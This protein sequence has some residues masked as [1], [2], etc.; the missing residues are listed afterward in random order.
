MTATRYVYAIGRALDPTDLTGLS[1][2]DGAEVHRIA[3]RDLAAV[4][5][6]APP[7]EAGLR[8]RLE[9]LDELAVVAE[10]HHAVVAAVAAR[11]VVVP[12]RLA[13]IYRDE[14]RVREVL[15]QRYEEFGALL[16]RLAGSVE[17]GVKLY[18]AD[19]KPAP[20]TPSTSGRS[21]LRQLSQ[22]HRQRDEK[23]QHA[24]AAVERV[25]TALGA[26]ALDRSRHRPQA[27]QLSGVAGHNVLN[28][29]YLV[30]ARSVT[31]FTE[32]AHRLA[33]EEPDLRIEVTGPWA[34]YSFTEP[35]DRS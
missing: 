29:A 21:Y 9:R 35:G 6:A 27:A 31:E 26:Y 20:A 32:L 2:V 12:F 4:V 23:W 11:T 1:G 28:A 14:H 13:T 7:D 16:D 10:A 15:R 33:A 5:S 34:P 19:R 18:A 22:R 24:S 30:P 8:S 25:D 3:H 17:I